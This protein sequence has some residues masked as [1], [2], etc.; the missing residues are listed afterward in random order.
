[1][2]NCLITGKRNMETTKFYF[3]LRPPSILFSILVF[4][5]LFSLVFPTSLYAQKRIKFKDIS[6]KVESGNISQNE[7]I[8]LLLEIEKRDKF[9]PLAITHLHK[10][11]LQNSRQISINK[12]QDNLNFL[13]DSSIYFT[14]KVISSVKRDFYQKN[15]GEIIGILALRTDLSYDDFIDKIE[16]ELA[17]QSE[18]KILVPDLFSNYENAIHSLEK[19]DNDFEQIRKKH[20]NKNELYFLSDSAYDITIEPLKL[21]FFDFRKSFSAYQNIADSFPFDIENIFVEYLT[22]QDDQI[23][24]TDNALNHSDTLK[25]KNYQKWWLNLEITRENQIQEFWREMIKTD[26]LLSDVIDTLST[27]SLNLTQD[28]DSLEIETNL[29][30]ELAP[31]SISLKLFEYLQKK[32]HVLASFNSEKDFNPEGK[33]RN[34]VIKYYYDLKTQV[35]SLEN[36]FEILQESSF[37]SLKMKE[38]SPF[39][40]ERYQGIEGFSSFL[41]ANKKEIENRNQ[42]CDKKIREQLLQIYFEKKFLPN[43]AIYKDIKVALFEQPLATIV[44]KDHFLTLKVINEENDIK[45]ISGYQRGKSKIPFVAKASQQKIIWLKTLDVKLNNG[46]NLFGYAD[47]L[48]FDG[49]NVITT[50]SSESEDSIFQHLIELN[51]EGK[52]LSNQV[53]NNNEKLEF[54]FKNPEDSLTI[55]GY[56][57]KKGHFQI[58]GLSGNLK[59]AWNLSLPYSIQSPKIHLC[60]G[61][62]VLVANVIGMAPNNESSTL[63]N[64]DYFSQILVAIIHPDGEI[65]LHQILKNKHSEFF[66]HTITLANKAILI[67]GFQGPYDLNNFENKPLISHQFDPLQEFTIEDGGLGK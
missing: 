11:Y 26:Q 48:N 12:L 42:Y 43:Y 56:Q 17:H 32:T 38:I 19:A 59:K 62:F 2:A 4:F 52:L 23:I 54:I 61:N 53:L 3:S 28:L 49:R 63:E 10:I 18:S 57:A 46:E 30:K 13:L 24:S 9:Y 50:I 36:Y 6:Q 58:E 60:Q 55:M 51:D 21:D 67:L 34:N 31:A 47:Q 44:E 15:K 8:N 39:L 25:V 5:F 65:K 7:K 41:E 29:I 16:Q 37:D 33:G 40:Q 22:V 64:L 27:D 66:T 1:M 45:Y 14:G 35:N 20:P